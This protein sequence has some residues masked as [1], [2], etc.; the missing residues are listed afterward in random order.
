MIGESLLTTQGG[1]YAAWLRAEHPE[2]VPLY[3]PEAALDGRLP[4]LD[5]AWTC[6]VP[7]VLH[8]N[9][10]NAERAVSF[11]ERARP[12][13]LLLV[14]PPDPHHPFTPPRPWADLFDAVRV[15]LPERVPGELD[16]LTPLASERPGSEWIDNAASAVEQG[17]MAA[18]ASVSDDSLRRAIALTQGMEAMIDDAFGKVLDALGR[19]GHTEDTVVV[20]T[21]DHG[22]FLGHHGLLHK[23]PPPFGDLNRI[24]MV[25]A[26]PG[27]PEGECHD[28]L[29]SHL[30]LMP[31]MLDLAGVSV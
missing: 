30:D 4:D 10:W 11:L 6:A 26:G 31:T 29:T 22:E 14:S 1:H 19:L 16:K 3:Q 8:Y 7:A 13:F 5:E 23:R 12:P 24:S 2:M 9:S 17:G 27:V 15:P 25:M 18:T 21:S 20:F 28:E